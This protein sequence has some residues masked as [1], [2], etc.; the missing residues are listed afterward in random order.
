MTQLKIQPITTKFGRQLSAIVRELSHDGRD[1]IM[2]LDK[3]ARDNLYTVVDGE[4]LRVPVK[5]SD[6]IAALDRL[7]D[8]G[9]GKVSQEIEL[10]VP[11]LSPAQEAIAGMSVEE[12]ERALAG[13][14]IEAVVLELEPESVT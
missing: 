3:I 2:I 6:R 14:S 8:R 4:L 12:M 5:T 11:E 7:M 10:T 9:Y 13:I 1:Y